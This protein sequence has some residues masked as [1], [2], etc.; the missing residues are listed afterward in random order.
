MSGFFESVW[1]LVQLIPPGRVATYGQIAAMLG[2]PRAARTVGW[3]LSSTPKSLD[4]PWHRVINSRGEIS[5]GDDRASASL[6]K[7]LLEQEGVRFGPHDRIDLKIYGWRPD[8]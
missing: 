6:Q 3:A 1:K 5:Q 8:L 2:N 4:I 7:E